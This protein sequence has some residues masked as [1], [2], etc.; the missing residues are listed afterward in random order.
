MTRGYKGLEGLQVV[1]IGKKILSGV[2]RADKGLR[3]VTRGYM[4][5]QMVTVGYKGLQAVHK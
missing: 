1:G 3:E 5:L 2:T 4:G